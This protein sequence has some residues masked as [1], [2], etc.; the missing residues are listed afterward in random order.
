MQ[1]YMPSPSHSTWFGYRSIDWEGN[2]LRNFLAIFS[3][4]RLLTPF[5]GQ[6]FP[7]EPCSETPWVWVLTLEW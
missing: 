2:N 1:F 3:T 4:V 7:L 5:E 6:M